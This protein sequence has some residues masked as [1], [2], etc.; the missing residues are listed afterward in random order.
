[1]SDMHREPGRGPYQRKRAGGMPWL[2]VAF[3]VVAILGFLA[4]T[5]GDGSRTASNPT[6]QTTGQGGRAPAPAPAPP[7]GPAPAPAPAPA[8]SR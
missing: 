7:P 1:M 8:P 4:W 2:L 3:A 5:M 6:D